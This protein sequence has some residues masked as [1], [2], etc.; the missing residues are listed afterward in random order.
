MYEPTIILNHKGY[1][2][3]SLS[4]GNDCQIY[5]IGE[6]SAEEK[7]AEYQQ[8]A[9]VLHAIADAIGEWREETE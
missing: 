6:P 1:S 8:Y 5:W 2:L 4:T 3:L 9:K 7:N